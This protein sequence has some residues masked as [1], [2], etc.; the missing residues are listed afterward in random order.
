MKSFTP[1]IIVALCI[2][3]Y[4]MYM[5]P[6]WDEIAVKREKKAEYQNVLDRV[7]ELKDM[8]DA[9]SAQYN[10]I[11]AENLAMLSKIIPGK[12]DSVYFTNDINSMAAKY[13]MV[14]KEM[15]VNLHQVEARQAE[16]VQIGSEIYKT[17]TA[18]FKLSGQYDQFL[19]FL[20]DL[21]SNLRLIDVISLSIKSTGAQSQAVGSKAPRETNLDYSLEVQTYSLQ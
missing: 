4:F 1:L 5:A 12:F 15:R 10:D 2:G 16:E 9:V 11:P 20:K 8:R 17:V 6:A 18:T 19:G 21:E 13:G 7:K 14:V 3:M